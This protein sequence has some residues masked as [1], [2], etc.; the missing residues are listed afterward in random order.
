MQIHVA[1]ME[2]EVPNWRGKKFPIIVVRPYIMFYYNFIIFNAQ[3]EQK[4][5]DMLFEIFLHSYP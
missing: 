4:N 1:K 3:H 5:I 2:N